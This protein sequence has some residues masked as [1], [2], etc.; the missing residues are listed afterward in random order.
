MHLRSQ[1]L[2]PDSKSVDSSSH[3]VQADYP[4]AL[5]DQGML[6]QILHMSESIPES[7]A[8]SV[9]NGRLVD[10]RLLWHSGVVVFESGGRQTDSIPNQTWDS[11]SWFL[12]LLGS[13]DFNEIV[14]VLIS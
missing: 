4:A 7:P 2:L 5:V 11:I 3:S 8:A 6:K 9:Q 10:T 13:G 14:D 1:A 12:F